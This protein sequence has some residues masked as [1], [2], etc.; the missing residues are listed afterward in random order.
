MRRAGFSFAHI[1][2]N[3]T[4]KFKIIPETIVVEVAAKD[5]WKKYCAYL[6]PSSY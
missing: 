5:N 6:K 3:L 4:C 1:H 2:L